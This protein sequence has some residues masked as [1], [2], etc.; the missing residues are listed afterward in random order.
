MVAKQ[1]SYVKLKSL[2]FQGQALEG[3]SQKFENL[4]SF[5]LPKDGNYELK[6][7]YKP[8]QWVNIGLII[9]FF[10]LASLALFPLILAKKGKN[11]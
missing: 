4:N 1:G 2:A 10:T 11:W 8:Q 9:N 5:V 7:Y 6:V 3:Y